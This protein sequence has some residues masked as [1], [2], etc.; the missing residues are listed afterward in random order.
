MISQK[1]NPPQ[2]AV[3]HLIPNYVPP[4]NLV[5]THQLIP[6]T[7]FVSLQNIL[8]QQNIMGQPKIINTQFNSPPKY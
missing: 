2:N 3:S 8:P 4:N 5:Q 1:Y 6:T 7:N